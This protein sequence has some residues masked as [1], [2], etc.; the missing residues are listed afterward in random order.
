MQSG[1]ILQWQTLEKKR[2]YAVKN[3]LFY[4]YFLI[5]EINLFS[6][7]II[8]IYNTNLLIQI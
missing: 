8:Q 7:N 5:L 3:L 1:Q 4:F 2:F 6:N